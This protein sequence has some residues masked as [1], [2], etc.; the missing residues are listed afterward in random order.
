MQNQQRTIKSRTFEWGLLWIL[1]ILGPAALA[2]DSPSVADQG[3]FLK[4]YC[5]TCHSDKLRTAGLTLETVNLSD[6]TQSGEALEKVVR[7]LGSGAMPPPSAPKPDKATAQ[8]FLTAL[9]TSLDQAA[10]AHPNPGRPMMMHRLNRTEYLNTVHD[11]FQ[12]DLSPRDASLLPP[13]DT[14][15][16]FDNN[17]DILGL[18]PLLLERYLSVAERVT[19]AALGPTSGIDADVYTHHVDFTV[20]QRK[21]IEGL[22]FGTRGGTTFTYR[23]PVDGEYTIRIKLQ[24]FSDIILGIDDPDP[25]EPA[26]PQR[27][28]IGLDGARVGLF[29][30]TLAKTVKEPVS[31]TSDELLARTDEPAKKLTTLEEEQRRA[32]ADA[33]L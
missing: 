23:F 3:A 18:S 1:L 16:G 33:G 29:A 10:A 32:T 2:Q 22:P 13:D 12:A 17:G 24:R 4:K 7:K 30:I 27:L 14:S 19:T 8:A 11:L 21:W 20:P 5:V 28:E 31:E 26:R 15:F 25:G 6:V 9:E